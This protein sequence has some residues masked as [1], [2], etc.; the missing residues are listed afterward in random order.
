MKMGKTCQR[1][2]LTLIGLC[3]SR[4]TAPARAA[5]ALD[6]DSIKKEIR[7][8]LAQQLQVSVQSVACPTGREMKGGDSFDCVAS[9]EGVGRLTVTVTQKDDEG[10]VH[11]SVTKTEG[12]LD[13]AKLEALIREALKA[14]SGVE[15]KV[16]CGGLFRGIRV[17]ETFECHAEDKDGATPTIK[18]TVKDAEGN[19]DWKVAESP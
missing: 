3:A 4:A 16:N 9:V 18:V 5:E 10:N 8:G 1:S 11:W 14:Q 13:L 12:L 17:G 15:V 6:M 7:E 19:V 2:I